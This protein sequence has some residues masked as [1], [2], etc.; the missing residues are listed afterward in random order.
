MVE[1]HSHHQCMNV[2][3]FNSVIRFAHIQFQRCIAFRVP[4]VS[5]PV[6]TLRAI[7]ILSMIRCPRT[8][9]L[10]VW[11]INWP[12]TWRNQFV[13]AR[14]RI[15]YT[16]LHKLIGRWSFRGRGF[17]DLGIR[18]TSVE[19]H[20]SPSLSI[21]KINTVAWG[22]VTSHVCCKNKAG[23]PSGTGALFGCISNKACLTST[24]M[25]GA[26]SWW[27]IKSVITG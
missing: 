20:A 13:I 3:P 17:L 22:P 12:K 25:N 5:Y 15:L 24:A 7:K 27:F 11:Y 14:A 26:T 1:A 19:F 16:I 2:S 21:H 9:A 10:W 23:K 4:I 18:V 8:N 6:H